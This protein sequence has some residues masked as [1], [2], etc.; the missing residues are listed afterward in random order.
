MLNLTAPAMLL[1]NG[2]GGVG[3]MLLAGNISGDLTKKLGKRERTT[4]WAFEEK[5]MLLELCKRDMII[6]EN[7]RLDADLT[8]LKN[9]A[10]KL[11]HHQFSKSFGKER[12]VNRLKEQWR[13]MKAY[14]RAEVCDYHQRLQ[15]CGQEVADAKRPSPFT[16]EI[17]E[18]MQEAKKVC[19]SEAM[20][21]MDYSR[22]RLA[23]ESTIGPEGLDDSDEENSSW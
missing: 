4:N 5:R 7:K 10:W 22:V 23:I 14:T 16:F 9:R 18:F 1:S 6:I 19:R 13:R 11:I 17:W 2:G 15:S 8:S 20:E 21:G 3:D 12:N